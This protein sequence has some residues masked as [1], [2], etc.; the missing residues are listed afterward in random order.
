MITKVYSSY[1]SLLT[2]SLLPCL[3]P[4]K[5]HCAVFVTE[6]IAADST[7][8]DVDN[9]AHSAIGEPPGH[10]FAAALT[11]SSSS[12]ASAAAK[13]IMRTVLPDSSAWALMSARRVGKVV[14]TARAVTS[15][16]AI[17][18]DAGAY[19]LALTAQHH[20]L[21]VLAVASSLEVQPLCDPRKL[22]LDTAVG[23]PTGPGGLP[24]Q[25]EAEVAGA[26]VRA[27]SGDNSNN[28]R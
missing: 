7:N 9:D 23:S 26:Q 6:G 25:L 13:P 2:R 15:D 5:R 3:C 21:P 28:R 11:R 4:Q 19:P 20:G 14:L 18:A 12:S 22:G 10:V 17:V 1:S 8:S 24:H 27:T 16:G